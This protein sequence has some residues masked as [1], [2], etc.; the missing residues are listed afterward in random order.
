MRQLRTC[1]FCGDEPTGVY[2]VLPASL[3]PTEAE[4]RR[5]ALCADC[6][7]TLE[8]V[9]EPLLARPDG[10]EPPSNPPARNPSTPA[11]DPERNPVAE[12]KPA[13]ESEPAPERDASVEP[14]ESEAGDE[15]DADARRSE[16]EAARREVRRTAPRGDRPPGYDKVLRL[17]Q[18]REGAMKRDD[19]RALVTN[20]Y[21][22]GDDEFD[23]VVD[24]AVENGDLDEGRKGLRT[25]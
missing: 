17:L 4:Q 19:L 21:G 6:R 18:N 25:T 11:T 1:D 23:A 20:A 5:V 7:E 22:L 2:E 14:D 16:R 12:P 13:R 3:A 8:S 10:A 15:A 24:A 9:L